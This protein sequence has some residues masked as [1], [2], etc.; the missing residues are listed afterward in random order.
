V[1]C[2]YLLIEPPGSLFC[3]MGRLISTQMRARPW[4]QL[5][6]HWAEYLPTTVILLF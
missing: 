2:T 6:V 3:W 5:M 4:K 1:G